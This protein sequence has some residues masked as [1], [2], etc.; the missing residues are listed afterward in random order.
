MVLQKK[1]IN[2][3]FYERKE[4][5]QEDERGPKGDGLLVVQQALP[6]LGWLLQLKTETRKLYKEE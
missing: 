1:R 3:D 5:P 6:Q 2:G 4:G